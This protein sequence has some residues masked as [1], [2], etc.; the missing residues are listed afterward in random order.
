MVGILLFENIQKL[1]SRQVNAFMLGIVT[2]IV[3]QAHSRQTGD[4][5][6]AV[7]VQHNQ[8]PRRAGNRKQAVVG[9]VQSHRHVLLVARRERPGCLECRFGPIENPDRVLARN[10]AKHAWPG[11]FEHNRFHVV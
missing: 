4:D 5:L 2:H 11:L 6:A 3:N 1:I 7:R 9:F 10:V 8:L